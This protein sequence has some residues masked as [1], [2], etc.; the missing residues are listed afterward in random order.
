M[1][2]ESTAE[3]LRFFF[4]LLECVLCISSLSL[5]LHVWACLPVLRCCVRPRPNHGVNEDTERSEETQRK[6]RRAKWKRKKKLH[7]VSLLRV[8]YPATH[9]TNPTWRSQYHNR[10]SV[11]AA[12]NNAR[13]M[14][15]FAH[16]QIKIAD[17]M[18]SNSGRKHPPVVL[19]PSNLQHLPPS[20]VLNAM[21]PVETLSALQSH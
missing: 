11:I 9:F 12:D 14:S 2:R 10:T 4:F 5:Q 13:R 1:R 19:W 3:N 17:T 8:V 20:S 15:S 6:G 7:I 16:R 21:W 18:S